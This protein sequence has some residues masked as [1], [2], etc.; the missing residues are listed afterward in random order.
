[1]LTDPSWPH[2]VVWHGAKVDSIDSNCE[3]WQNSND[4]RGLGSSL[5]GNK[6]LGGDQGLLR[7]TFIGN[8]NFN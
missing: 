7:R 8:S 6:L 3:N 1:M 5:L 2:K 4:K